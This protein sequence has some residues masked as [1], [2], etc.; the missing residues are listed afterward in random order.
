MFEIAIP[1]EPL[2]WVG[3]GGEGEGR[4]GV[5]LVFSKLLQAYVNMTRPLNSTQIQYSS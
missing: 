3:G 1:T 4:E 2:V 5:L